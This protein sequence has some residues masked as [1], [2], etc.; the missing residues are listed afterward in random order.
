VVGDGT[1][2][3]LRLIGKELSAGFLIPFSSMIIEIGLRR[4]SHL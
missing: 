3:A 2:I 1:L 4:H